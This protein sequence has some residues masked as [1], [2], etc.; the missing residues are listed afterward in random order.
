MD[1]PKL[2]SI[3]EPKL[4]E[5]SVSVSDITIKLKS[6]RSKDKSKKSS[7]KGKTPAPVT[8]Y[9]RSEKSLVLEQSIR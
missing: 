8:P 3:D 4:D 6:A 7:S 2:S 5:N 9:Q 1:N